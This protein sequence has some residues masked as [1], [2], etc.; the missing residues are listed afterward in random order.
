L[1][2]PLTLPLPLGMG[3]V[4]CYLIEAGAGFVLVDTGAPNSRVR[5]QD[6][7]RR[8]GCGPG[9][10]GLIL[11]THGDFDHTGN[12]ACLRRVFGCRIGMHADDAN[13]AETGDMFSNRRR[14]N[15][16]LRVLAPR[17][18]GFGRADRFAPDMILEDGS[19]LAACGLDAR[20]VSIPGH[21]KGS[22]GILTA[23][24]NFF[25]GDLLEN[26]RQPA[27]NSLMD[28]YLAGLTS[29]AKLRGL[30][31]KKIYP[32]H[33]APFLIERLPSA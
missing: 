3:S 1:I 29:L 32:G 24:G 5:L 8:L 20:V 19:S 27:L 6:N 21:S 7:L 9:K 10:L 23:D 28:D 4:N 33:G 12:A 30:G 26:I 31:I 14:S 2:A 13:M 25:C 17:L 18:I 22:I 11:L 16:I 15:P